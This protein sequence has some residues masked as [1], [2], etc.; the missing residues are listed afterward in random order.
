[1]AKKPKPPAEVLADR[2][3]A[4]RKRFKERDK[5][6][7]EWM[8]AGLAGKLSTEQLATR[9]K[10]RSAQDKIAKADSDL[11]VAIWEKEVEEW[12]DRVKRKYGGGK[13]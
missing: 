6:T 2:R 5:Q 13:V 3:K 9:K 11:D 8:K 12:Q 1:M 4:A 10:L 7:R